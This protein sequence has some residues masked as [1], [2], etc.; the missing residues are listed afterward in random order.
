LGQRILIVDDHP[1][2]KHQLRM[3]LEGVGAEVVG[4]AADGRGAVTAAARLRP[5]VV[6]MD[7]SMPDMDGVEAGAAIHRQLPSAELVILS[8]YEPGEHVERAEAA[9][10]RHWVTKSLPPSVLLS[11]LADIAEG[12]G[13][14][15]AESAAENA[16][17]GG[18]SRC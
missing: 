10:I 16:M 17:E 4:E 7:F 18:V 11:V 13:A 9:G 8:V 5:D 15:G 12:T 3:M 2:V 6:V 14:N 1:D